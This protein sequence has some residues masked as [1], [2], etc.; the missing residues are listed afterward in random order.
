MQFLGLERS[1]TP[2]LVGMLVCTTRC[3]IEVAV[4]TFTK[5]IIK[6]VKILQFLGIHYGVISLTDV[7]KSVQDV[8][9]LTKK[10]IPQ[11]DFVFTPNYLDKLCLP[12]VEI[13]WMFLVL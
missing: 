11:S 9:Q 13:T 12:R 3:F 7:N 2:W 8:G 10:P 4:K 5:I 1:N 6:I